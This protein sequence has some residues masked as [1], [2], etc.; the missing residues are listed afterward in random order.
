MAYYARRTRLSQWIHGK[1]S[2][3][4]AGGTGSI[5]GSG[6]SPEGGNG[7]PL[8]HPS[9]EKPMDRGAWTLLST[10]ANG[11]KRLGSYLARGE[12]EMGVCYPDI[13]LAVSIGMDRVEEMFW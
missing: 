8:Q 7:N 1:E 5:P 6:K 10:H 4:N 11:P 3:C 2:A 9:L 13:V 12:R